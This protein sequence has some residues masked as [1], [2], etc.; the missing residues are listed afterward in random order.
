MFDEIDTDASGS[1]SK[2][3]VRE[4]LGKV[5]LRFDTPVFDKVF[6]DMD[7]D[8]NGTISRSEFVAFCAGASIA[9][10]SGFGS[11]FKKKASFFQQ[12]VIRVA[13]GT[14]GVSDSDVHRVVEQ[15]TACFK[16]PEEESNLLGYDQMTVI[17]KDVVVKSLY[18]YLRQQ[19]G[20]AFYLC[21]LV[22]QF[23]L[24]LSLGIYAFY[25]GYK[26]YAK[27]TNPLCKTEALY[28]IIYG[29][30]LL[31]AFLFKVWDEYVSHF[32]I[33]VMLNMASEDEMLRSL[34]FGQI[35]AEAF[36]LSCWHAF[37]AVF[38]IFYAMFFGLGLQ[39]WG[40]FNP[41]CLL[42]M[43]ILRVFVYSCMRVG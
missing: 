18:L 30:G 22:A 37:V 43:S 35:V 21:K 1:L 14:S 7:T 34:M 6:Q 12:A 32:T 42:S 19:D 4:A 38:L 29:S 24:Y 28:L 40:E 9:S 13:S 15:S 39:I 36:A 2:N 31:F 5:D 25:V 26:F 33:H 27:E 11:R 41:F 20:E 17:Q 8:G 23:V 3:E 10:L 16:L